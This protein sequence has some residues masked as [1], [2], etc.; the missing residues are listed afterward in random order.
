MPE[1][2]VSGRARIDGRTDHSGAEVRIEPGGHTATTD[3]QG[4]YVVGPLTP[5]TYHVDIRHPGHLRSGERD[6]TVVAGQAVRMPDALLLGGDINGDDAID[7]RDGAIC[8]RTFGLASGDTGFDPRADLTGDGAIDI[9]DL[10]IL[11][12]NFG[13]RSDDTTDRCRRWDR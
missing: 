10:A 7:I 6:I 11:G 3:A 2:H 8:G 9:S 4:R 1:R 12:N 13:C 5:G